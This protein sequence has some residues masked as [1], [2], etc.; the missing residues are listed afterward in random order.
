MC[1]ALTAGVAPAV[2]AGARGTR[3]PGGTLADGTAID[4]I[5]LANDH[6]VTARILTYGATLQS[7]VTPDC[8]G[9][10]ADV[11]LGYDDLASYVNHP[12]FFGV[13]VGR[14]ANRIAGGTF[15]ID[16]ARVQ[17]PV[18]DGRNSL[19]G[20]GRGFD[21]MAWKVVS[22]DSGPIAR[23]RARAY[24]PRRAIPAIPAGSR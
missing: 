19:H 21:K 8:R 14:F 18:N 2:A 9:V 13:T 12:N 3:A 15:T 6:G 17:L 1:V 5:T 4:V 7:L 24:Q 23:R 10:L 22:L 16:G 11:V 20:G